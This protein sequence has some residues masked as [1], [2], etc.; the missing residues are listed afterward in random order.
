M[1]TYF[2]GSQLD[3]FSPSVS[4]V[5]DSV[6]GVAVGEG[7]A[8]AFVVDPADGVRKGVTRIWTHCSCSSNSY[9]ADTGLVLYTWLNS[10]GAEVL[11]L[12]S[13]AGDGRQLS[14][15]TG[16]GWQIVGDRVS[17]RGGTYDVLAVVH[18][19]AGRLAWFFNGNL[20]ADV[21]GLD[22]SAMLDIARL[23]LGRLQVYIGATD[24]AQ[25]ILASYNTIGH[26]VRRRAP[27]GPGARQDWSGSYTDVDDE[28]YNDT[29]AITASTVGDKSTF[30]AAPFSPVSAGN[31]IK[32]VVVAAR[33]RND[34]EVVPTNARGILRINGTDYLAP[35]NVPITAGF[36]GTHCA[37]DM[38]PTTGT[39]W[40]SVANVNGEFGLAAL[41]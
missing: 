10:A 22:T 34:G 38:D 37:F 36:S 7:Y 18:P 33:I 16:T 26:T 20:A 4:G 29:D 5:N 23:R 31:V 30:T 13:T 6:N 27:T 11:R 28:S 39:A 3:A 14:Y 9:G 15:W 25:C 35:A 21:R 17:S 41:A 2:A 19:T 1:P 32:S 8:D 40:A 24:H 12:V